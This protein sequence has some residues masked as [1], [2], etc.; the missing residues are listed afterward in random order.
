MYLFQYP[1]AVDKRAG[2]IESKEFVLG[3]W[4][5]AKKLPLRMRKKR[6]IAKTSGRLIL[7]YFSIAYVPS[8]YT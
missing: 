4:F 7:E 6:A 3:G 1:V 2:S 5:K 8:L